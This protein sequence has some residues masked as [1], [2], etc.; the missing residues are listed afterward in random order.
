MG[1]V[2]LSLD[3]NIM[4]QKLY[5]LCGVG[6]VMLSRNI[7]SCGIPPKSGSINTSELR[8]IQSSPGL[9]DG[10]TPFVSVSK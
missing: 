10:V 5:P 2:N 9:E 8:L 6:V 3:R 1:Y 7:K 4:H